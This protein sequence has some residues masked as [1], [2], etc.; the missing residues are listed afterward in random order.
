MN[1][2]V[3]QALRGFNCKR[4][5]NFSSVFFTFILQIHHFPVIYMLYTVTTVKGQEVF[6]MKSNK[7][8]RVISAMMTVF[9]LGAF[10]SVSN[11]P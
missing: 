6:T 10:S 2:L 9:M 3:F 7:L 1:F 4:Y 5:M 8:M 11:L